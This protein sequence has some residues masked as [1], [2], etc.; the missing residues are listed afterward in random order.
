M[1]E[2]LFQREIGLNWR[3]YRKVDKE[4]VASIQ[5]SQY[6]IE[7]GLVILKRKRM[8]VELNVL[9]KVVAEPFHIVGKS[10]QI[11]KN[12]VRIDVAKL[13]GKRFLELVVHQKKERG[14]GFAPFIQFLRKVPGRVFQTKSGIIRLFEQLANLQSSETNS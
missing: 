9:G 5:M 7:F 1:P 4:R 3:R 8:F 10:I 12:F 13:P 11:E 2:Y 14:L 6:A